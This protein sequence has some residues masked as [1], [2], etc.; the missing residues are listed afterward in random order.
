MNGQYTTYCLT[1]GNSQ[2]VPIYSLKKSNKATDQIN[3]DF[4]CMY[5][6]IMQYGKRFYNKTIKFNKCKI[7]TILVR[8]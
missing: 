6:T 2:A 7:K 3:T 1:N 5:M 4:T 8:N